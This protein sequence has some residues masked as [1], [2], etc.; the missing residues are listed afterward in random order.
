M[1]RS[2]RIEGGREGTREESLGGRRRALVR[3]DEAWR[4]ALRRVWRRGSEDGRKQTIVISLDGV[5]GENGAVG[6]PV[7]ETCRGLSAILIFVPRIFCGNHSV[8]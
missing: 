7:E 2:R 1:T 3:R 5:Q 4:R 8:F 6:G